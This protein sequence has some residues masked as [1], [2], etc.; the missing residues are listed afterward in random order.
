MLQELEVLVRCWQ[1]QP[2]EGRS[3][4]GGLHLGE[5]EWASSGT[6]LAVSNSSTQS[7]CLL[8]SGVLRRGCLVAC[9]ASNLI[10]EQ[11]THHTRPMLSLPCLLDLWPFAAS[12]LVSVVSKWRR[13]HQHFCLPHAAN[14]LP[15]LT[16]DQRITVE[17]FDTNVFMFSI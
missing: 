1:C 2:T 6:N 3:R 17:A 5:M 12:A 8:L 13:C 15:C 14:V 16:C 10:M 7:S 9:G 11:L 4:D